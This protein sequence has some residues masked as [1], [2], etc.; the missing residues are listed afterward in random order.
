M[1]NTYTLYKHDMCWF[2]LPKLYRQHNTANTEEIHL[3]THNMRVNMRIKHTHTFRCTETAVY[4]QTAQSSHLA[5][6]LNK[7]YPHIQTLYKPTRPACYWF[8]CTPHYYCYHTAYPYLPLLANLL[9]TR[10]IHNI[11]SSR[12]TTL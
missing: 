1:F 2:E 12:P 3:F 7:R 10:G 4:L 9:T 6:R 11:N 5:S 8:L